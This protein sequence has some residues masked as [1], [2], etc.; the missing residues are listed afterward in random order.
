MQTVK[1]VS[2]RVDGIEYAVDRL[3]ERL[4]ISDEKFEAR[5]DE[6]DRRFA[7]FIEEMRR[8]TDEMQQQTEE[9]R[10]NTEE[11]RRKTDTFSADMEAQRKKHDLEMGRISNKFGTLVEDFV[12]PSIPRIAQ[13]IAGGE[14]LPIEF[15]GVHVKKGLKTGQ[16]R[17]FDAIVVCGDILLVNETKSRLQPEHISRFVQRLG[18]V[19]DWFP[20]YKD[21]KVVGAMATLSMDDSLLANGE[22]KGLL[23][24]G[25]SNSMMEVWNR[26]GFVPT[27]Y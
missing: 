11:I 4:E 21:R 8:E 7:L 17:E 12:A 24:L 15:F 6:A 27:M 23:M 19:R 5:M 22:R 25:V 1:T 26:D 14:H 10:R 18:E 9:I 16:S 20:E 13:K 2:R 3:M